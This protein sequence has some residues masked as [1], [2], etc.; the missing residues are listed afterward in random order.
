MPVPIASFVIDDA[1]AALATAEAQTTIEL[2]AGHPAH[3]QIFEMFKIELRQQSESSV[4]DI[5]D[6]EPSALVV[7]PFWAWANHAAEVTRILH[8]HREDDALKFALPIV[9][10]SL[11]F[12][13]AVLT[14]RTLEIRPPFPPVNAIRSFAEAQRRI[15]LTATLPD[16]TALVSD[17]DAESESVSRPITPSSASD[18]GDRLILAP[19]EINPAIDDEEIRRALRTFADE[20]NVVVLVPSFRRAENWGDVADETAAAD[21]IAEVVE[22]LRSGHVGLVVLVNKYDGIDLPD[23]ACRILVLDGLPEVYGGYERRRAVALG[24]SGAIVRKQML[25]I[26]QGMGRGVRSTE[27]FCVVLLLGPRLLRILA[28]WRNAQHLSPGTKAQL[29]LSKEVADQLGGKSLDELSALILQVLKRDQSWVRISRERLAGVTYPPGEVDHASVLARVAFNSAAAGQF[30]RAVQQ[31]R[32]AVNLTTDQLAKGWNQEQLAIYQ[33][34]IDAVAAQETL[35]GALRLNRNLTKPMLGIAF[36]R[37]T[38]AGAQGG[39]AADNLAAMYQ[40]QT[41]LIIGVNAILDALVFDPDRTDEFEQAMA[42]LGRHLGFRAQRP[43]RETGNGPDVLWAGAS[44]R[45]FVIECKSGA[46]ASSIARHDLAQ[47]GHSI[48][49]YDDQY[50]AGRTRVPILIHPTANVAANATPPPDTRVVDQDGLGRIRDAVRAFAVALAN[51]QA[52]GDAQ[53]VTAQLR[54]QHLVAGEIASTFGK[55][56]ARGR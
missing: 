25:R 4:M 39:V 24:G 16:D 17:F 18:L 51:R 19:Q 2:P 12:S 5:Q 46:T 44:D 31:M 50:G 10:D 8:E 11:P 40:Q 13:M 6:G 27:D 53:T 41:E 22:R 15:F 52:W 42:D 14:A 33:H 48:D 56:P 29:E 49:W 9:A 30:S 35:A 45:Y 32:E 37:L 3:E 1:H 55:A 36:E 38:P 26:E 54:A 23:D 34:Q 43:D 47:L 21:Q 20:I 28:D 7:V